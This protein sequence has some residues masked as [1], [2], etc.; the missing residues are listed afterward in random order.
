MTT[1]LID[2]NSG[3]ILQSQRLTG[4]GQDQIFAMV[5]SLALLVRSTLNIPTAT[6]AET[7]SVAEVTT[8]SPEAYR[9][10]VQGIDLLSKMLSAD[11]KSPLERAIELD[12]DFAMA[13]FALARVAERVNDNETARKEIELAERLSARVTEREQLQI[14]AFKYRLES[15][16]RKSAETLEKLVDHYPHEQQA[17]VDLSISYSMLGEDEKAVQ[18]CRRGLQRDPTMKLLWN[19]LAYRSAGLNRRQEALQAIDEYLKLAPGEPNPYDTKGDVYYAFRELDSARYWYQRAVAF[20]A[21]F[22]SAQ[23][24]CYDALL[25][26][27]YAAAEKYRQEFGATADPVQKAFAEM[28]AAASMLVFRGQLPRAYQ[29]LR[30]LLISHEAQNLQFNAFGDLVMLTVLAYELHD[31]PAMLDHANAASRIAHNDPDDP[32]YARDLV[33]WALAKNGNVRSAHQLLDEMRRE[34]TEEFPGLKSP[35]YY[36]AGLVA[37]EEGKYD[38]AARSFKNVRQLVW[39]MSDPDLHTAVSFLKIGDRDQAVEQLRRL[40]TTYF[41]GNVPL[42][43]LFL[44]VPAYWPISTIKAHY[45]L[46]VA[47]EEQGKKDEAIK[48]YEKF[49]EIWRDADF[50][51]AELIDAKTR[52]KKLKGL[53]LQ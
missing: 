7:R 53:A 36:A 2:V 37:F 23:K 25:R 29:Q 10:Y 39:P 8:K 34:I 14:L 41:I 44:P 13:H 30:S 35:V 3:R 22:G 19:M 21:N 20:R 16:P 46:G 18:T 4:F 27:D 1:R 42:S 43:L 24:L 33:A 9:S 51:S 50:E 45:W 5:D 47:Y 32:I 6:A 38:E 12:P 17:Y 31:Y 11:A 28:D 52:L 49:L 15:N 48:E 40:T 26:G